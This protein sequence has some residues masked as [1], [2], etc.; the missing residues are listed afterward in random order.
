MVMEKC[1]NIN[2]ITCA[3]CFNRIGQGLTDIGVI[4]FDYDF[5]DHHAMILFDSDD[6]SMEEIIETINDM[7]YEA[8]PA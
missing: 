2:G 3:G 8:T 5:V 1:I 4:K 6:T 7:G